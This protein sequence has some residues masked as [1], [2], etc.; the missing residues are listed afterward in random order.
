MHTLLKTITDPVKNWSVAYQLFLAL[1]I[2]VYDATLRNTLFAGARRSVYTDAASPEFGWFI[3]GIMLLQT[4]GLLL[5]FRQIRLD[6]IALHPPGSRLLQKPLYFF[7]VMHIVLSGVLGFIAFKAFGADAQQDSVLVPLLMSIPVLRDIFFLLLMHNIRTAHDDRLPGSTKP[8]PLPASKSLRFTANLMLSI[9]GI[10]LT[11]IIWEVF[12]GQ[13]PGIFTEA[14]TYGGLAAVL[15]WLAGIFLVLLNYLMFSMPARFGFYLQDAFLSSS[16]RETRIALGSQL[17][18][19]VIILLP[20][21][22][23]MP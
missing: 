2:P 4:A 5:K 12:A 14:S 20:I 11:T 15:F 10:V 1:F 3:I 22:T 7:W 18:T 21:F 9:C 8:D 16:H 6:K 23:G 13:L 17:L 19:A